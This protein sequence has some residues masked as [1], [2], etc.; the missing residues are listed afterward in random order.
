MTDTAGRFQLAVIHQ[1]LAAPGPHVAILDGTAPFS[2]R[3][4]GRTRLL[5]ARGTAFSEAGVVWIAAPSTSRVAV[6]AGKTPPLWGR[7]GDTASVSSA[8]LSRQRSDDW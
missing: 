4:T 8:F 7:V 1:F 3:E 6:V 2:Y 5:V